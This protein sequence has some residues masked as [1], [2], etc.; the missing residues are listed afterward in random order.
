MRAVLFLFFFVLPL[1]V[2]AIEPEEAARA[3]NAL[4]AENN[5]AALT[6]SAPLGRAAS[7]HAQDMATK[8]YFAHQGADGSSAGERARAAGYGWCYVAENIAKGQQ[9]LNA[10]LSAWE[11]SRGHRKNMLSREPQDFA[12]ARAPGDIWVLLLARPGC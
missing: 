7:A 4:R 8:G 11:A 1:R 3:L 5:R 10:A 2:A 6:Y 12:L 9:S